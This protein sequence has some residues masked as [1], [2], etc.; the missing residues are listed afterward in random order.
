[1]KWK[2]VVVFIEYIILAFLQHNKDNNTTANRSQINKRSLLLAFQKFNG[3]S[4][5]TIL[6]LKK[7]SAFKRA[8]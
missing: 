7:K 3:N 1:M 5:Q 6:I 4:L 8:W 2:Q